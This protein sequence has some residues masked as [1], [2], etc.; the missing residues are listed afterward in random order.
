M[1]DKSSESDGDEPAKINRK[2]NPSNR[3][4]LSSSTFLTGCLFHFLTLDEQPIPRNFRKYRV[5][6]RCSAVLEYKKCLQLIR[7]AMVR[8]YSSEITAF[9]RIRVAFWR[10]C[11]AFDGCG[12]VW[13]FISF[14]NAVQEGF[15][16]VQKHELKRE[17]RKLRIKNKKI[18]GLLRLVSHYE[19][20]RA[21]L[22]PTWRKL[23]KSW[24]CPF[25]NCFG[26]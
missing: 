19:R 25:M 7:Y 11:S 13:F 23:I 6:T 9:Q 21:E 15:G 3:I 2:V 18:A 10:D 17:G 20:R 16:A 14:T 22:N 4:A 8:H 1:S 5:V 12:G 24:E 26:R